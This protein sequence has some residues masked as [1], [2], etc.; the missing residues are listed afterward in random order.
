VPL[1]TPVHAPRARLALIVGLVLAACTDP[2]LPT[3]ATPRAPT[4]SLAPAPAPLPAIA[5]VA[6]PALAVAPASV[7]ITQGRGIP[8]RAVNV[9]PLNARQ[10]SAPIVWS[11]SD[12]AV[13]TVSSTGQVRGVAPGTAT[14]TASAMERRLVTTAAVTVVSPPNCNGATPYPANVSGA[15]MTIP[16]GYEDAP[17]FFRVVLRDDPDPCHRYTFR[18]T[19][20]PVSGTLYQVAEDGTPQT[21]APFVLGANVSNSEGWLAF[22]PNPGFFGTDSFRY[23]SR[24]AAGTFLGFQVPMPLRVLPVNDPPIALQATHVGDN[25]IRTWNVLIQSIDID[26]LRPTIQN[27]IAELPRNGD[28]YWNSVSPANLVVRGECRSSS[29]LR[30]VSRTEGIFGCGYTPQSPSSYP[31]QVDS[32]RWFATDGIAVSDTVADGIRVV[33]VNQVPAFVGSGRVATSEDTPVSFTPSATD[34]DGDR[35][36]FTIWAAPRHGVL[37]R[38]DGTQIDTYPA[39]FL[40]GSSLQYL[41]AAQFNTLGQTDD[42][43]VEFSDGDANP[44]IN[45]VHFDVAPVNDAPTIAAPDRTT[46]DGSA[47]GVTIYGITI[48]DDARP[49]DVLSITLRAQGPAAAR[50]AIANPTGFEIRR[51]SATE[52]QF[53]GTLANINA[54]LGRGVT[55]APNASGALYGELAIVVD[56]RGNFGSGGPRV[57]TRIVA[58]DVATETGGLEGIRDAA[59]ASARATTRPR[60]STPDRR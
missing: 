28:L 22:Y 19:E 21:G 34:P 14:I 59:A 9:E 5:P 10:A 58:V 33:Y 27:C 44:C 41:P 46:A 23:Q 17:Q 45:T 49:T 32:F 30:Y 37:L 38:S 36:A 29:T 50:V 6:N 35:I 2:G 16:P 47:F 60:S 52:V 43:P 1:R 48:A 18:V 31:K 4:P 40:L 11:S 13:A 51:I 25:N 54:L 57:G 56:D 24:D 55:W 53:Q 15:I 8:L 26:N 3:A 42:I 12:P 7:T 20:L 39:L